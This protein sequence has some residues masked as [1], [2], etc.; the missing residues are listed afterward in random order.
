MSKFSIEGIRIRPACRR[1]SGAIMPLVAVCLLALFGMVGLGVDGAYLFARKAQLQNTAD[2]AA[3]ACA[4]ANQQGGSCVTGTNPA[5]FTG[6]NPYNVTLQATVPMSCPQPWQSRCVEVDAQKT[7]AS[8]FMKLL[9][10]PSL[11]PHAR[12]IAGRNNPCVFGL[13]TTGTNV[14]FDMGN[15]ESTTVNCL[16]GSL[17][18][19]GTSVRKQGTGTASTTVGIL[20]KGGVSG[21][22]S[23]PSTII[24]STAIFTDPYAGLPAPTPGSCSGNTTISTCIT[25]SAGCYSALT[26][27]PPNNCNM[28][29]SP[30][31]YIIT[32]GTLTFN[33]GNGESITGTDV[34]FYYSRTG[35]GAG[36]NIQGNGTVTLTARKYGT[37][38][39]L[40]FVSPTRNFSITGGGNRTLNG[41]IYVPG[42]SISVGQTG[43]NTTTTG[44]L[45]ANTIAA[46][47]T[48]IV[49]DTSRIKLLQ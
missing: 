18:T 16:I 46:T 26:L 15:G 35:T 21:T 24:N 39:N 22:I 32:T 13:Q 2:A 47:N 27:N 9:G 42:G 10:T 19:A 11:T 36:I 23:S 20:T 40:L 29:M 17:S 37:Y 33:P 43:N 8:F 25:V 4:T 41:T 12:A 48:L 45:V 49:N 5:L 3:L 28:T 31:L 6:I 1:Q 7:W 34:N 38:A 30:G 44:N 14:N